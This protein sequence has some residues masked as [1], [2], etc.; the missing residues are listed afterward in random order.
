MKVSPGQNSF[1]W[2]EFSPH[3]YGQVKFERYDNALAVCENFVPLI[4]GPITRRP[5]TYFVSEVKDSTK[6]TRLVRFEFSTTQAY[7][8][9]FGDL[10]IR[11]YKDHGQITQTAQNITGITKAN[12]AVVTYDGA[13][14]YANGEKV[15]ISGVSGMIEV[16]NREF[17]VANVNAGNNTFELSGVNSS[18]YTTYTSGGTVAEIY[19]VTTPYTEANLFDLSFTQSADVLYIS[20]PSYAPR[21]LTRTGHTSWTLSTITFLDGPYLNTNVTSTTVTPSATTGAGISLTASASLWVSTDVGRQVRIKHS[22]TWGYA[23]ITGYTSATVVTA[24]VNSAFGATTAS[25]DWRLGVW[26]DTTGYPATAQFYEDR[27]FFA[28]C[29]NYP[30]RVDGSKSGDYENFA[31]TSTAGVIANDNALAFSLNSNTVDIVRWMS[32]DEKGLLIGTVGSEW[33]MRPSNTGEALSPTNISAKNITPYGSSKTAPLKIGKSV[34]FNQRSGAKLR[35]MAYLIEVDGFR[36]PDITVF[37]EHITKGGL[38]QMAYQQEPTGNLW[39]TRTDG[40]LLSCLFNREQDAIGWARHIIGG[41][42]GSGNAV[43]DSVACI[44]APAGTYDEVWMIVKRT[45]NGT[46][47]RYVEYMTGFFNTDE[48]DTVTDSFFVDSGLTY[49]GSPVSTLSGLNHLIG[50]TVTVLADGATHPTCTVSATGTITLTRSASTIHVGLGYNSN[51]QTLKI[52]AGAAD[53]TAQGKT[54]RIHRV[55]IRLH[56]TVG[57][58]M[59]ADADNLDEITFRSP[60]DPMNEPVPLFTGDKSETWNGDYDTSGQ[61]YIRQSQPLPMTVVGIYP[62][63]H[64]QDR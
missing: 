43:V 50:Q 47:K 14:T 21:K 64:T 55:A 37:A 29:T 61:I 49:S 44:P 10:Y 53:G 60:S 20:H 9:E 58:E 23:T 56:E 4:Q 19:E 26:S 46:T 51:A 11:F 45:I 52:E 18:A 57:M 28:G 27:L 48:G 35:D 39:A 59:G 2:G 25:V 62:Q 6:K 36:S 24:T 31:P 34:L 38:T 3:M 13:D 40:V 7:I 54:K 16:N 30:T 15:L 17:T 5:G 8:L 12:P 42:F 1:N 63:L 32:G 33:V 22:S 41:S